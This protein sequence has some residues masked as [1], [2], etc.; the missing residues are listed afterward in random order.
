MAGGFD[1]KDFEDFA[2]KI[3]GMSAKAQ[4]AMESAT[5]EVG[6]RLLREAKLNTKKSV[7]RRTGTLERSWGVSG[8]LKRAGGY[9]ITVFNPAAEGKTK[10][11]GYVEYGHRTKIKKN[12]KRGWVQGRFMLTRAKM[13]VQKKLP[14]I[15]ENAIKKE[16]GK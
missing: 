10:Y 14:K 2:K 3:D 8:V 1:F 16:L 4:K 7:K 5:K 11:A 12:G 9:K 13:S 15:I 6:A